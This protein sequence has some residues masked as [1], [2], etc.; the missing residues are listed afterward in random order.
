LG[1]GQVAGIGLFHDDHPAILP[2]FP[3]K[4]SPADVHGKNLCGA[5]LQQAIGESTGGCAQVKR[6]H[7]G[8][9]QMKMVQ[10]LFQLVS[11]A[12]YIFIAGIQG[13]TVI[14]FD[15]IAGFAGG[16][17]VDADLSGE[18][19]AFGA[20]TAFAKAAFNQ[21]LVKAS[22]VEMNSN[23]FMCAAGNPGIKVRWRID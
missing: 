15:G 17:V 12:A 20:F 16:L 14:G 21:G 6:G 19:G 5:V 13:K 2:E 1:G 9:I 22:H 8:D 7:A 18:N 4:L 23:F 10:G 11:A 3:G